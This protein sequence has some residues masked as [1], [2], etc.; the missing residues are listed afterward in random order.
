MKQ[1]FGALAL[2]ALLLACGGGPESSEP[3]PRQAQQDES[4][5]K[6]P[7]SSSKSPLERPC[8]RAFALI[9]ANEPGEVKR[10]NAV[11]IANQAYFIDDSPRV[12]AAFSNLNNVYVYDDGSSSE[13]EVRN[14]LTAVCE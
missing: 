2:A 1:I 14:Q 10:K 4:R 13:E 6:D 12:N 9:E 5:S 8:K 3:K 11:D 7:K